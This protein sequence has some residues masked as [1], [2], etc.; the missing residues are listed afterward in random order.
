MRVDF[1]GKIAMERHKENMQCN[2]YI[3][4]VHSYADTFHTHTL[5]YTHRCTQEKGEVSACLHYAYQII[6]LWL[7]IKVRFEV[8]FTFIIF[9]RVFL[10]DEYI[11]I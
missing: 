3:T 10:F 7:S 4:H 1:Q 5:T 11:Y 8:N 2:V 9:S 6:S